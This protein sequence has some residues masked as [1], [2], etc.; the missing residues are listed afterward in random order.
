V[1]PHLLHIR[2]TPE[3]TVVEASDAETTFARTYRGCYHVEVFAV[4]GRW[5]AESFAAAA[6]DPGFDFFA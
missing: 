4:P 2:Q 5:T 1:I 3:L 6:A